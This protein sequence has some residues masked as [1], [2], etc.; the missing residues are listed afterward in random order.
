MWPCGS[1]AS[2]VDYV[3]PFIFRLGPQ[4]WP[5]GVTA[6]QVYA[7]VDLKFEPLLAT[8]VDGCRNVGQEFPVTLILDSW[9]HITLEQI[10]DQPGSAISSRERGHLADALRAHL[11]AFPAFEVIAGSPIASRAG[12]LLDL[13]P[14]DQLDA[15]HHAV[16]TAVHEVRGA[17]STDYPVLPCHLSLGY[18]QSDCDSDTVQSQL[19]RKVRPGH[20]PLWIRA[21]HLVEVSPD[22]KGKEIRWNQ[23]SAVKIP[24]HYEG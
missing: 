8:L 15:L 3:Q 2:T 5:S 4:P 7:L 1:L 13:H 12:I 14:D 20:A 22:L 16:R 17:S 11:A 21:V 10:T 6:L 9:L 18:A 19:Q 23:D 24:L